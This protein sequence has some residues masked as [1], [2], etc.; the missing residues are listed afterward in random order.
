MSRP[1]G[2]LAGATAY[3]TMATTSRSNDERG[4]RSAGQT[5]GAPA[6]PAVSG[7]TG[8]ELACPRLAICVRLVIMVS[9]SM[10][11]HC[12]RRPSASTAT[13]VGEG[14]A[15][16][17]EVLHPAGRKA[18]RAAFE[19]EGPSTVADVHSG[20][21][22]LAR[23]SMGPVR[24]AKSGS[25]RESPA[26]RYGAQRR[27]LASCRCARTPPAKEARQTPRTRE[28]KTGPPRAGLSR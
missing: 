5:R 2:A 25:G 11:C 20:Q 18:A 8:C 14:R 3:K 22:G 23:R 9:L 24:E 21:R 19:R 15:W 26:V 27:P 1:L 13:T 16:G 7:R 10:C 6:L 17:C 4:G 12:A 28:R